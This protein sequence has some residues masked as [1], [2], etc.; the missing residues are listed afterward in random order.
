MSPRLDV[1]RLH[2]VGVV[3]KD[4]GR[5]TGRYAEIFG[6]D[7][8]EVRELGPDQLT[9][10]RS[11]GRAV[12]APTLRTATATT[13]PPPGTGFFGSTEGTPVTFELVQPVTGESPFMEF[14]FVRG[15]GISHLRL[16]DVD[17][18]EFE[19]LRARCAEV[20]VD[21]LASMTVDGAMRRHLLDTRAMLGGYL[22]EVVVQLDG[23]PTDDSTAQ[24]WDLGGTYT[25]PPGV[26]PVPVF[27]V[28]HFGVVVDDTISTVGRYHELF[29]IE[30]WTIR[31]WRTEPGSLEDPTYRGESVEHEYLTGLSMFRDFGF[32]IIQPTLGPSH[33]NREFRDLWGAGIHHMLLNISPGPDDWRRTREWLASIDVPVAMSGDLSGGAA[34]FC[35]YDT[36]ESLGG[37]ILEGFVINSMERMMDAIAS[38]GASTDYVIDFAALTRDL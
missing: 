14:R 35:Y 13:V 6:M 38:A 4:I 33:Y 36:A 21:V 22:V 28:N 32:E 18:D 7:H 15:Q 1:D 2:Q 23:A 5:A 9:D 17:A 34:S 30:Q 8:W 26:G 12:A 10:V 29:G 11:R 3:V 20:G 27:G 31:D 19:A 16:A 25:R 37:Y 24:H